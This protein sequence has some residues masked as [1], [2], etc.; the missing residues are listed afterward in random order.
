MIKGVN[1]GLQVNYDTLGYI[2]EYFSDQFDNKIKIK[3]HSIFCL[4]SSSF[5]I[6]I[7]DPNYTKID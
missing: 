5:R 6:Q 7:I 1:F 2:S 3:S 4:K